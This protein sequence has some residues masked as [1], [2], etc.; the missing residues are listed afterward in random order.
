[1]AP[2][3]NK[4]QSLFWK[5]TKILGDLHC[6]FVAYNVLM[7]AAFNDMTAKLTLIDKFR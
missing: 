4:L 6:W 5:Y 2:Q 3:T 7:E 1:M